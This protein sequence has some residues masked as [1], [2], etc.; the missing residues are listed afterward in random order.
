MQPYPPLGTLYAATALRAAGISVAIFDTTFAAPITGF[1]SALQKHKPKIVVI[2]EDDFNFVT[3]MCLA[4]M[5]ELANQLSTM[6]H[7]EGI[8]VIAHG[9]DA[10]DHPKE[11]LDN[12]VN[13]VLNGE[14][15]QTLT[16]LCTALLQSREPKEIP[17]LVC[18]ASPDETLQSA[19]KSPKNPSWVDLPRIARELIDLEP[20]RRPWRA[21]H[22]SFSP[23][24]APRRGCPHPCTPG[25]ERFPGGQSAPPTPAMLASAI[26]RP[27]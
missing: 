2:Y 12:G 15:E 24:A 1:A 13:Y 16:D 14:A 17:G 26:R 10:T 19:A 8:T 4:H 11:Y 7:S 18:Y 6:A 20:Y 5:R 27:S 3:K 21:K 22:G 23:N 9:S 25:P